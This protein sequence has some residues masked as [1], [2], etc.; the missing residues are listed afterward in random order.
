MFLSKQN[1]SEI[2]ASAGITSTVM[3]KLSFML[4]TG[5]W[6]N[7]LWQN[8]LTSLLRR[9]VVWKFEIINNPDAN[10]KLL[11]IVDSIK[12]CAHVGKVTD[13]DSFHVCQRLALPAIFKCKF[14][15]SVT[16]TYHKPESAELPGG[17]T[18]VF[19][20]QYGKQRSAN[21]TSGNFPK[22]REHIPFINQSA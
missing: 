12:L 19:N 18:A 14:Y 13:L 16:Y 5:A 9:E 6:V 8:Y 10:E 11:P 20:R 3:H 15:Q 22:R 1:F 7:L 17:L 21:T 2:M 4:D